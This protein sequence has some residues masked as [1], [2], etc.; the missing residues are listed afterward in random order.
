MLVAKLAEAGQV[1]RHVERELPVVRPGGLQD[2]CGDV[3]VTLHGLLHRVQV[4]G[5][6]D[7]HAAPGLRR[8]PGGRTIGAGHGVVM[9]TVEMVLQ[10]DDLVAPGVGARQT[11]RHQCRFGAAAVEAHPFHGRHQVHY[12]PGPAQFL[13]GT[14]SE[15]GAPPDLL[16]HG[17]RDGGMRVSQQQCTVAG[18]VVDVLVA[19]HVP[20]SWPLSV[21]DIERKGFGVTIV[22]RYPSRE[23]A[24]GVTITFGGAGVVC[25]VLFQ[26]GGHFPSP[27]LQFIR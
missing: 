2:D 14:R 27:H 3:A 1:L 10:F 16:R 20:L 8:N 25:D 26:D 17:I 15:V 21:G 6:H 24:H 22:V 5:R 4:P 9:P 23:Y 7:N 11:H 19:V 12:R 18:H 13:I